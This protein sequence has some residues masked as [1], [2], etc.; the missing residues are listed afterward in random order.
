[1]KM[2]K[3]GKELCK[4][5]FLIFLVT[6][7]VAFLVFM[8][9]NGKKIL[10]DEHG[11]SILQRNEPGMGSREEELEVQIGDVKESVT[12]KVSEEKY[13]K[14]ELGNVFAETAKKLETLILGENKSLDEVRS[15]LDLITEMPET[16]I[17]ISWELDNYEVMDQQ[18]KL[19]QDVLDESGVLLK[20]DAVLSYEDETFYHTFYAHVYPRRLTQPERWIQDLKKETERLDKE[21]ATNKK[22]L[23]P[24]S[25]DGQPVTWKYV[26]DYRALGLLFL[27]SVL[28]ILF[29]A[30]EGQKEKEEE[31]AR[32]KQ[33]ELDY[34]QLISRFTLYLGAG[35]PVRNAW[36]KIVQ[37]YEEGEKPNGRREVYEE[38]A[39]TMHEI[40]SGAS[41]SECYERFGERCG[42]TKYRKFG[43]LLSQ[44][45]KKG[46]RGISELL[47]QEA[48]QA[49]EERKDFAKKLG[50][51]AGTKMLAPMFLML[52]VV[53]VIIVV[54]A[55]FSV[56]I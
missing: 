55:F 54:P 37:S 2:K 38:M 42:L 13:T 20:L 14:E 11:Q 31:K 22:M 21:Q 17:R 34:P 12:V 27:G 33:M 25:V 45:L 39:Y 40:S 51:E 47:K 35:L 8:E 36:I 41:E 19:R 53:L 4:K 18:G 23:L 28:A 43:T 6:T 1:M 50:E 10:Q 56:Q 5:M 32:K 16:G 15:D 49:F 29:Y 3:P 26:T 7:G 44:N 46:S 30:A 48:F 9:D 24:T 52:G